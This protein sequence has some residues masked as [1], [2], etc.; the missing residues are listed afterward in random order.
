MSYLKIACSIAVASTALWSGK[1]AS[2][3]VVFATDLDNAALG[4]LASTDTVNGGGSAT[5]DVKTFSNTGSTIAIVDRGG[6]N[7]AMQFTDNSTN[8]GLAGFPR[9]ASN[10]FTPLSTNGTGNNRLYGSFDY[11]RLVSNTGN[12]SPGLPA[13]VFLIS[14][15]NQVLI[16]A[17]ANAIKLS[18][19]SDG[20]IHYTTGGPVAGHDSGVTLTPGTEYHFEIDSD[21]SSTTQDKWSL[22]VTPVGSTTPVFNTGWIN[23]FAANVQVN[24]I[25]MLAGA[26]VTAANASPFVQ[27]DN[28]NFVAESVTAVPEPSVASLAAILGGSGLFLRR[29][30]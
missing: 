27:V 21:F 24:V 7:K 18:V 10:T 16:D 29:K 30:R 23:T 28:F 1:T 19:E 26:N 14:A 4:T 15:G 6:G 3:V 5:D 9:A 25:S 8:A 22:K 17:S 12:G 13:F 11:T 20:R 2:A